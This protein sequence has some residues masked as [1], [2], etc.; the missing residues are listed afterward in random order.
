MR[1]DP[2]QYGRMAEAAVER[3]LRGKGYRILGRNVRLSGGEL[4]VVAQWGET[5]VFVEVKA[6]RSTA[7]GGA[8][9][10]V[11]DDKA[12]RIAKLAGQFLAR[13]GLT[14]R[15]CRFDVV[16][17]DGERAES[18]TIRHIEE[19]FEVSEREDSSC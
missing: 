7:Y 11:T 3:Y 10:A 6:R 5:I 8:A 18:L 15:P 19:A 9:Y 14:D 2:R 17:C 12:R 4:D 16:L 13:K 1:T